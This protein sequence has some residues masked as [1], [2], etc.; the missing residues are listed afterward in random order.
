[1]SSSSFPK[2]NDFLDKYQPSSS[3]MRRQ[4]V[5]RV[6]A[7]VVYGLLLG[8]MYALVSGTIDAVTFPDLPLRVDGAHLTAELLISG[9]GG[10]V[11]G[12][13]AAWPGNAW[14]GAFAGG[15]AIMAWELIRSLLRLSNPMGIFLLIFILPLVILSLPIA[16]VFRWTVSRHMQVMQ[17]PRRR[18]RWVGVAGLLVTVVV[19]AVFAGSWSRMTST[20]EAAV[21]TVHRA[22]QTALKNSLNNLPDALK[23]VANFK[24]KASHV[25]WLSQQ[26]SAASPTGVDVQLTFD[27]GYVVTCFVETETGQPQI[28]VCAEGAQ[29]T[30]GP[31]RYNPVDQR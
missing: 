28:L 22:M 2:T 7:G 16:G 30:F 15:A 18:R 25:Y 24:A 10:M 17:R 21:R 14:V 3:E 12:G 23:G 20:N 1:M 19:L 31:A 6:V 27:N 5:G 26:A 9:L 8:V 4:R 29:P 13:V 11:L